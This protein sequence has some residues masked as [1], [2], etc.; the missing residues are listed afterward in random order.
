MKG[1]RLKKRASSKLL[2]M[3]HRKQ[4]LKRRQ[5]KVALRRRNSLSRKQKLWHL[6][7]AAQVSKE[8]E[9]QGVP[10]A[11]RTITLLH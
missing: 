6:L 2:K 4:L 1:L 9:N 11:N 10:T 7:A 5:L 3:P 8:V